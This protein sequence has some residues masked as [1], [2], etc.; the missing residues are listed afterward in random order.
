VAPSAPQGRAMGAPQVR[1]GGPPAMSGGPAG[2]WAG[3]NVAGPGG[4]NW[5]GSGNWKG[6]HH[7][8]RHHRAPFFASGF[9]AS[10]FYD[11]A[12]PYP[13]YYGD[14]GCWAVRYIRGAYR[15]VWV[16]Y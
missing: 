12:W 8:H 11:D 5:H 10:Y 15:R 6:R 13:Y 4:S 2:R 14:N 16:C 7:T 3:R 9:A 1:G